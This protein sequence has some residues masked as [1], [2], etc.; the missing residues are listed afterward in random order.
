[1][2]RINAP[3]KLI[4]PNKKFHHM[5]LYKKQRKMTEPLKFLL[6]LEKQNLDPLPVHV[7]LTRYS[8]KSFDWDNYITACKPIRD[9]VADFIIPGKAPGQADS[10]PDIYWHY[11][12]EKLKKGDMESLTVEIFE[13]QK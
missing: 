3:I 13:V 11:N 5:V 8:K 10:S 4:S 2:I 6:K 12:Q 9:C 7:R 1:M